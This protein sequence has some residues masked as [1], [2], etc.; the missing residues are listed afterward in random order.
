MV[1]MRTKSSTQRKVRTLTHSQES[2]STKTE[3][4]S[5]SSFQLAI[6]RAL[7]FKRPGEFYQGTVTAKVKTRRRAA[8]KAARFARRVGR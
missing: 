2:T 4:A 1:V 7:Q 5:P 8:N 3:S 6:L